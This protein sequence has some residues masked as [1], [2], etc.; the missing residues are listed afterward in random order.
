M[1]SVDMQSGNRVLTCGVRVHVII[2]FA[3]MRRFSIMADAA[4][5]DLSG[6]LSTGLFTCEHTMYSYS[7]TTLRSR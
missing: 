4:T 6:T 7:F 1:L 2:S 5:T 3:Y